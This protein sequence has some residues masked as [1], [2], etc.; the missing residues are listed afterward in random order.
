MR[1][2]KDVEG[3]SDEDKAL[4]YRIMQKLKTDS[5]V[6]G[7]PAEGLKITLKELDKKK[8]QILQNKGKLQFMADTSE[9]D[10][11]M[12]LLKAG[13]NGEESLAEW[14]ERMVKYDEVMSNLVCFASLSDPDQNSG[15]EDYISDSDFIALYGEHVLIMDAKNIRTNPEVPIY[16]EGNTL[17]GVGGKEIMEFHPSVHVWN[18]IFDKFG[19]PV[20]SCHGCVV[21]VN[22]Q[23]AC[24]WRNKDWHASEVKPVHISE[25]VQFLHEWTDG[26][27]PL[28]RLSLLT[29]CAKM[30]IRREKPT[31][32][33]SVSR[34][35]FGV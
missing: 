33:L 29:A 14:V 13:I 17:V 16:L 2:I 20:K 4:A 3:M 34:K 5:R 24:I 19:I 1:L 26:K 9:I 28:F 32:D 6:F 31:I 25:L 21:I 10:E 30:Q 18:R 11:N 23:G 35:R 15:G 8:E 27:E 22:Q 12:K 7:N